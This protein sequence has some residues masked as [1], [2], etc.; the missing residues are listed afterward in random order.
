VGNTKKPLRW[1]QGKRDKRLGRGE[2]EDL[3]KKKGLS[4]GGLKGKEIVSS[5]GGKAMER[6]RGEKNR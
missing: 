5:R 1:N 4:G 2:K 6:E 3:R